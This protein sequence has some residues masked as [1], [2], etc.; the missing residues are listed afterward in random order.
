MVYPPGPQRGGHGLAGGHPGEGG[1]GGGAGGRQSGRLPQPHLAAAGHPRLCGQGRHP[2]GHRHVPGRGRSGKDLPGSRR[3][4]TPQHPGPVFGKGGWPCH[5]RRRAEAGRGLYAA[6]GA[7]GRDPG[8][9]GFLRQQGDDGE[10]LPPIRAGFHLHR[11]RLR[12]GLRR[13][14]PL[15][16]RGAADGPL[17]RGCLAKN[18]ALRRHDPGQPPGYQHA[19]RFPSGSQA[20]PPGRTLLQRGYER[21][22]HRPHH[23]SGARRAGLCHLGQQLRPGDRLP[24]PRRAAGCS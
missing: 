11:G 14:G 17:G 3:G 4:S 22:L 19:L 18:L 23:P 9:G 7:E 20:E 6:E 1:P 2:G 24:R 15:P 13:A 16:G 21:G 5:R 10:I 12:R 8:H